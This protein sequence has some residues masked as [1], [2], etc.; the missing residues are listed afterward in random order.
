[1]YQKRRVLHNVLFV[2]TM[3]PRGAGAEKEEAREKEYE[4]YLEDWKDRGAILRR[5][6]HE[7]TSE[8]GRN[9]FLKD[10][11][12]RAVLTYS[13]VDESYALCHVDSQIP[14]TRCGER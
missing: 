5:F 6:D 11:L 13:G 14:A 1:M 9:A 3:W 10:L 8:D 7:D 4:T 2:T 12:E